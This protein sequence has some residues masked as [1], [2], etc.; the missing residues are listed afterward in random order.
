MKKLLLPLLLLTVFLLVG[1]GSKTTQPVTTQAPSTTTKTQG[2]RDVNY[3][4]EI[5]YNGLDSLMM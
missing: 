1:C 2:Q 3:P 4:T 5:S